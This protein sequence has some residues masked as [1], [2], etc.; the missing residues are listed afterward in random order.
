MNEIRIEKYRIVENGSKKPFCVYVVEANIND[1]KY[2]VEKRY[3][4]FHVLHEEVNK[5]FYFCKLISF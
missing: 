2:V 5:K 3:S 1:N 4:Q